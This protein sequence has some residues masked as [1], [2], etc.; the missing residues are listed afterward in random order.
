MKNILLIGGSGH[1]S[2]AIAR[3]GVALGHAVWTVTRGQ[4]PLLPGVQGLVADRHVAGALEAVIAAT[5]MRWDLVVDCI[6]FDVPDLRQD[7]RLFR[8]RAAQFVFISTDFVY[9]PVYRRYPQ[10]EEAEQWETVL[11]YG[12]NKRRCEMELLDG[13][14]GAMAWTIVRPCHIYGPTSELGCLPLHGR[15]PGLIETLRAGRPVRLV[16]GGYFLQQPVLADDLALTILSVAGQAKAHQQIFNVAGPDIIESRRYYQLIAE[17]LG[18]ALQV[19][20]VP[21][22]AYLNEHP[23]AA[24]FMCHRI[25][26]LR[27]LTACGLTPPATPIDVGLRRHVEGLLL[28][29]R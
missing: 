7:I 3:A 8:D 2:G 26:D 27:K 16:G 1:V 29:T 19:E 20:E 15:D 5:D 9:D 24:P 17:T 18:V 6:G 12:R 23:D 14:T 10:P 11:G 4:R 22:D 28:R 13:D 21:V 25:Y